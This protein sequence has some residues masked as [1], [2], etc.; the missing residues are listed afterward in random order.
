M[1]RA[2]S[3]D[4]AGSKRVVF[5]SAQVYAQSRDLKQIQF[6]IAT[7][8][9]HFIILHNIGLKSGKSILLSADL[10]DQHLVYS[11]YLAFVIVSFAWYAKEK[12]W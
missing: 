2:A 10:Y 6:T 8:Y 5:N 11:C 4:V 1:T 9:R 12:S 7:L 3:D